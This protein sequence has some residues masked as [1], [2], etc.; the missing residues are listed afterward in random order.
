M[1]ALMSAEAISAKRRIL[2]SRDNALR[3]ATRMFDDLARPVSVIRTGNPLQPY[4]VS[5]A[6]TRHEHVELAMV[7]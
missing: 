7:S 6:P 2:C 5:T 1:A 3:V 4:R